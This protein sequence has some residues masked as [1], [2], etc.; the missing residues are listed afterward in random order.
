M[1]D[2]GIKISKPGIDVNTATPQELAF[3]SKYKTL[4]ISKRGNGT[5]TDSA[6]TVTIPHGLGYVPFFLVHTQ[7]DSSATSEAG[8]ITDYFISPYRLGSAIEVYEAENTHD[9]IAWADSTNLYIKARSNVG[10][11]IYPVWTFGDDPDD[12]MA[13]ENDL[14][15][16]TDSWYVGN[17]SPTFNIKD[18]A[19]RMKG[20]IDLDNSESIYTATL[21]LYIGGRTGTGQVKMI[22]SGIDEDDTA[23][24][25]TG[26][27][28]TA[29]A[30]TTAT[31]ASNTNVSAGSTVS[32]NVKAQVQEIIARAGWANGN[33]MG[34]IMNDNGTSDPNDYKE[35]FTSN[36]SLEIMKSS[37]LVSYKYT[38]FLNQLE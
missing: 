10:K 16:N 37:N 23:V 1:T 22:V 35:E 11:E 28:A 24:F 13:Y 31:T 5:L 4:K 38:I 2:Y 21:K 3:S 14:G 17:V 9:V 15:A 34:F 32:I 12:V 29:R 25:S 27:P 8:D 36:T 33:N 19:V 30:K 20:G 18:G 7:L 6:R 26:T